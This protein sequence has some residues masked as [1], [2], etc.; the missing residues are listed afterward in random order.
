M[1]GIPDATTK[2]ILKQAF[3]HVLD[4]MSF[5]EPEHQTRAKN[6]QAYFQSST[7]AASTGEFSI[8][9]GLAV[10][11]TLAIPVLDLQQAGAQIVPLQVSRVA[12]SKR[13]Y[14]KTSAGST[15]AAFTLLV[16]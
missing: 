14:L 3:E 12:D 6:F 16:E 8:A 4:N 15:G 1:S 9:H 7:T 10:A 13:I 2:R 5:G 11:P